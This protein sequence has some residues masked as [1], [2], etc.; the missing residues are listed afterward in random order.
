MLSTEALRLARKRI[1]CN[2]IRDRCRSSCRVLEALLKCQAAPDASV[3]CYVMK[4]TPATTKELLVNFFMLGLAAVMSQLLQ[5]MSCNSFEISKF[6]CSWAAMSSCLGE[7]CAPR[8]QVH[9][10]LSHTQRLDEAWRMKLSTADLPSP[11]SSR[12]PTPWVPT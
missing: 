10:I 8:D 6:R 12:P 5:L 1:M 3:F 9:C 2:G 7:V 4:N 11:T